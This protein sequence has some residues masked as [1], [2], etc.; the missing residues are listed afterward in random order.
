M[1]ATAF[2]LF[3]TVVGLLAVKRSAETWGPAAAAGLGVG[4]LAMW[5]VLPLG[6][7]LTVGAAVGSLVFAEREHKRRLTG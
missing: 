1:F 4:L 6:G 7:L 3:A 2:A 5:T